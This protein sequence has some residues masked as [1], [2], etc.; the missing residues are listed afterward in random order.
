MATR[1]AIRL[2]DPPRRDTIFRIA[3]STETIVTLRAECI[4]LFA[5]GQIHCLARRSRDA[6][7]LLI[8]EIADNVKFADR[9]LSAGKM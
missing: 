6:M 2:I 5:R 1:G 7:C 9:F 4:V 8:F 3:L